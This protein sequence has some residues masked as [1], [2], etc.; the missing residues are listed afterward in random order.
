VAQALAQYY[1]HVKPII[2]Y[3]RQLEH[4]QSDNDSRPD[5]E[6]CCA[7]NAQVQRRLTAQ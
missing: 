2:P 7:S 6:N 4:V 3:R 1:L 5:E